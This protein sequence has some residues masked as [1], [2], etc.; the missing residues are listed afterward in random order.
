MLRADPDGPRSSAHDCRKVAGILHA[1]VTG[2]TL[3]ASAHVQRRA[4]ASTQAFLER[5][6]GILL[7]AIAVMILTSGVTRM[8]VDVLHGLN[9]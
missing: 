4:K 9:P 5:I 6:A 1:A 7:T 8:V 2:A 3:Y